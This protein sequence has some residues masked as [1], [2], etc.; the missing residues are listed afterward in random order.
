MQV[1]D[2]IKALQELPP[3]DFVVTG[4]G[5]Q[6]FQMIGAPVSIDA[7]VNPENPAHY[8]DYADADA[9]KYNVTLICPDRS[10]SAARKRFAESQAAK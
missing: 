4:D 7:Y 8:V 10:E 1:K 5:G 2:L 9:T 3:D 6:A